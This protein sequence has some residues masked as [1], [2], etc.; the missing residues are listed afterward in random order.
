MRSHAYLLLALVGCS[1]V[2]EPARPVGPLAHRAP[3][4]VL[5]DETAHGEALVAEVAPA[6]E[7]SDGDRVLRPTWLARDGRHPWRG[8]DV[9]E[10]RVIPGTTAVLTI[11]TEHVLTRR[12]TPDGAAVEL[13]RDVYGPLSMDAHGTAL[14]YTRGDP[15][16]LSLVRY[17]LRAGRAAVMAEALVPAWSP[18][19]SAD[20]SEVVVVASPEGTPSLYRVREGEAPRP[21]VLPPGSPLPTGPGAPVVF[22]DALVF[23]D[24]AGLHALGLDG[25]ARRSLPGVHGPVLS[26]DGVTLFA[27]RGATLLRLGVRDLEVAR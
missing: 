22:G 4:E 14:A 25:V 6:P 23:E 9:L 10:A 18:A 1:R 20:G 12:A 11:T 21:W 19:L 2:V 24:E 17:D 13:D 26:R 7:G 5:L 27:Q 16:A 15:P 8:G 3:G